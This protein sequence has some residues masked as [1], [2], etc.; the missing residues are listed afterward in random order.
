MLAEYS[1]HPAHLAHKL[2]DHVT[3]DEAAMCEPFAISDHAVDRAGVKKGDRVLILGAGPIGQLA[4]VAV[5]ALEPSKVMVTDIRAKRLDLCKQ[6][7]ADDALDVDGLTPAQVADKARAAFG[8]DIDVVIDAAGHGSTLEAGCLAVKEKGV[9][10]MVG[11]ATVKVELNLCGLLFRG[12]CQSGDS[13]TS[14]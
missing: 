7:G 10:Q 2:E 3:F 4:L 11:I 13:D 12:S 9:V 14:P 8:E 6:L 1:V 5:K